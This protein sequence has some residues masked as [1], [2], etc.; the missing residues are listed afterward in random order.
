MVYDPIAQ[1]NAITCS[2]SLA[3]LQ[4]VTAKRDSRNCKPEF[5][6]LNSSFQSNPIQNSIQS[7]DF[8]PNHNEIMAWRA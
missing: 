4:G 5:P 3:K 1:P 7:I 2:S 8:F 6:I